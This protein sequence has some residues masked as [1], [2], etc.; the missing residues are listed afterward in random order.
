MSSLAK[1]STFLVNK[2]VTFN[3]HIRFFLITLITYVWAEA[4]PSK[5]NMQWL[6]LTN[7]LQLEEHSV[8]HYISYF[9]NAR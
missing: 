6:P 4:V 3:E 9:R 1:N 8:L 5:N 7:H 2:Y